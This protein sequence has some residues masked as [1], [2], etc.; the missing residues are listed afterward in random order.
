MCL[1]ETE[2]YLY[3]EDYSNPKHKSSITNEEKQL[4]FNK[5]FPKFAKGIEQI[6]IPL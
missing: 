5:N 4:L 6:Y 2:N 1:G 3:S